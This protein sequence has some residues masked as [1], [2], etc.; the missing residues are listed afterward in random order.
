MLRILLQKSIFHYAQKDRISN[1][2]WKKCLVSKIDDD[3]K[4]KEVKLLNCGAT[5]LKVGKAEL[6]HLNSLV[7]SVSFFT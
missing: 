5:R 4:P 6:V 3:F 7:E 1:K 2:M